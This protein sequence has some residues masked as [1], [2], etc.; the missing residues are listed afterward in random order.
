MR[1]IPEK[2]ARYVFTGGLAAV[3]DLGGFLLLARFGWPLAIAAASSFLVAML[4]HYVAA[5]RI[6][7]A[8]ELSWGRLFAFA[9]AS[10]VGLAVNTGVTSAAAYL[11]DLPPALAKLLGIGVAFAVNFS[12]NL[13]VTFRER[14]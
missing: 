2:L 8:R 10:L 7:F 12:V 6:V 13:L 11:F 3:V 9:L 4:F 5:S 1:S 14:H